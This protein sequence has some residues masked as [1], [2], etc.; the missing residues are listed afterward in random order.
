MILLTARY[1]FDLD[2]WQ[3]A[4]PPAGLHAIDPRLAEI[5]EAT[6]ERAKS[7]MDTADPTV[8]YNAYSGECSESPIESRLISSRRLP[9]WSE[10]DVSQASTAANL[11]LLCFNFYTERE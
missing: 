9:L 5:A 4:N 8:V 6:A 7:M 10:W 3:I 11:L 1:L 2:G